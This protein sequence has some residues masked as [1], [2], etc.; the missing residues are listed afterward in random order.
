MDDF[1]RDN[2]VRQIKNLRAAAQVLENQ[3]LGEDSKEDQYPIEVTYQHNVNFAPEGANVASYHCDAV[4]WW[5]IQPPI[6]PMA[7]TLVAQMSQGTPTGF[8]CI[9]NG[10]GEAVQFFC[11]QLLSIHYKRGFLELRAQ[12]K[13]KAAEDLEKF[14]KGLTNMPNVNIIPANGQTPEGLGPDAGKIQGYT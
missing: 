1:E 7:A 10:S 12:A 4:E 6:N 8:T 11:Y 14:Q 3:L 5:Y 13:T 2:Q 9:R